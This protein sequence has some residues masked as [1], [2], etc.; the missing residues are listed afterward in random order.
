MGLTSSV[1]VC[2]RESAFA[3]KDDMQVKCRGMLFGLAC[4]VNW[5]PSIGTPPLAIA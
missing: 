2:E 3:S 4:L 1:C 5:S